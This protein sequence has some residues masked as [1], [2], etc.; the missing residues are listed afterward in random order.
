MKV[1]AGRLQVLEQALDG[2]ALVV[3]FDDVPCLVEVA[4]QVDG[5]LELPS[6]VP[7]DEVHVPEPCGG[8]FKAGDE[9]AVLAGFGGDRPGLEPL[10]VPV[11]YGVT[12]GPER[13]VSAAG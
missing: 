4:H 1:E 2:K 13:Q 12:G 7:A 8:K 6:V 5:V 9:Q 10:A 3:P 11:Q